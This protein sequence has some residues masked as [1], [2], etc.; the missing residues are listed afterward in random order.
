M[1]KDGR[2]GRSLHERRPATLQDIARRVGVS[3]MAVS[4]ALN[5]TSTTAGVSEATRS[6]IRAVAR[7]L[8]YRPNALARSLRSKRT[9]V[10]GLYSGYPYLDPR[11]AF[12]AAIIGGLQEGCVEYR[13]DLLLHTDFRRDSVEEIYAEL[14][15]GRIDGLVMTAPPEDPLEQRLAASHLP[16]V[17][18]ADA[19]P[20]LPSVVVDDAAGARLTFDYLTERGHRRLLYR[21]L[22]RRLFSAER[23]R[24]AYFAVAAERGLELAEWCAPGRTGHDDS[25]LAGWLARPPEERPTAILCWNDTAAYDLL[26]QCDRRGVRVPEELAVFGFDGDCHPTDFRWRLTTIRA[27]WAA[28]A[29]TAVKL[30][31]ALIEGEAVPPKTVLPVDLVPGDSA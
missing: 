13:K 5:D 30:L 9:N 3:K 15:D 19:A 18:V 21:S 17:V 28:V 25:F 26:A 4:A 2:P 27:P 10:I 6:R 22:D 8:G 11:N 24:A 12:F 14:V 20:A 29:R 7:E 23:R 31:V 1:P 16:V